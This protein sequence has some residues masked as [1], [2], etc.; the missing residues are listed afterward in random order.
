MWQKKDVKLLFLLSVL[1]IAMFGNIPRYI[2]IG[3]ISLLGVLSVVVVALTILLIFISPKLYKRDLSLLWPI[4]TFCVYDIIGITWSP[5]TLRNTQ[6]TLVW[7][8]FVLI[9]LLSSA[10]VRRN[11]DFGKDIF[12]AL[13][14][15]TWI[16]PLCGVAQLMAGRDELAAIPILLLVLL[17]YH[18]T[19]W[20]YGSKISL[21][22]AVSIIVLSLI[23][24]AR[25]PALVG[26]GI[27]AISYSVKRGRLLS[28][29]TIFTSVFSIVVL[30]LSIVYYEPLRDAFLHGDN[31]IQYG[32]IAINT[33][34]RLNIWIGV[35]Q[36]Y[37]ENFV[38]GTGTD[39]PL[40][41][42]WTKLNQPHNDYLRILHHL[43]LVG[44]TLWVTFYYRVFR[45]L[46][47][48][49][50]CPSNRV[51][52]NDVI[53]LIVCTSLSM[54]AIATIMI[55]TNAVVYSFVMFP[56]AVLIGASIGYKERMY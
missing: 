7:V 18:I 40:N 3:A 54:I 24:I 2:N 32:D 10:Q 12:K 22:I 34:G 19:M 36:S 48:A 35:W 17:S 9:I 43:G 45:S 13:S 8:G 42:S 14:I 56:M 44:I 39:M 30:S 1:L 49:L 6:N 33:S 51:A 29:K 55:A 16:L 53:K 25:G 38:W 21:I 27:F 15:G 4:L 50:K 46:L 23:T 26:A 5:I 41:S 37:V 47:D 52:D 20:L 11:K 31:A 28:L